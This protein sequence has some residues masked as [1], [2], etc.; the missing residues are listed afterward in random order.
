MDKTLTNLSALT[1][2]A[3]GVAAPF[4]PWLTGAGITA[5]AVKF[6]SQKYQAMYV[7]II[8]RYKNLLLICRC[9]LSPLTALCLGAYI[10]DLTSIL[11]NL[12][13]ATLFREPPR[14]LDKKLVTDTLESYK[15]SDAGNVHQLV[16]DVVSG[17]STLDPREKIA[18]LI[19]QQLKMDRE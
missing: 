16:R 8:T 19:R 18:D 11:H 12:F 3:A 7:K 6:L 10:V 1:I 13:R 15:H 4:A 14:A 2:F 17:T 9:Q 5:V